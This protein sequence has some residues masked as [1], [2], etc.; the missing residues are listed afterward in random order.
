MLGVPLELFLVVVHKGLGVTQ[1]MAEECLEF[2]PCDRDEG[3]NV[4]S[5]LLLLPA[6]ADPVLQ[7]RRGKGNLDRSRS[8][9][10]SKI[11][12]ILLIEVI[13]VHVGLFAIYIQG[14]GLQLL[15]GCLGNNRS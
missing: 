10:G 13:A 9:S 1:V 11:V 15:P 4:M 8:S 6:E 5:P 14:T 12:L 3:F 7:E 2:V